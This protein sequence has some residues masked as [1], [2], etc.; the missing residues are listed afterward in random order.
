MSTTV[1]LQLSYAGHCTA[2]AHHA[3]KGAPKGKI[4]FHALWGLIK[5]PQRGYILFDTG[6]TDR[7][8]AATKSWPNKIYSLMT[9]VVIDKAD[10]VRSRLENSGVKTSDVTYIIISH[11]HADHV[12][13][14]KDFPNAQIL[15]SK[16]AYEH[17][18]SIP[19]WRGFAKGVL[20][21][22][23]PEDIKSRVDF[24]EDFGC[25]ISDPKL[26]VGYDLFSDNSVISYDLPGHAAGQIGA[27][28]KTKS[29]SVFLVADAVWD[30]RAITQDLLPHPI[31]K[32]FFDSW[33]DSCDS[34]ERI[35]KFSSSN[36][37]IKIIPTHCS[38][39]TDELI[40]KR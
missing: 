34:I 27:V 31:V 13:G 6:Y 37:E 15:C 25:A 21:D 22:L 11:F 39:T 18:F 28:V 26:G 38:A 9:P 4:K 40:E 23:I 32:L 19:R 10:E 1:E 30:I 35:R 12:A 14:L 36:P 24:V 29:E 8:F 5:H 20:F 17:T 3:V 16:K 7:F 2:S 33:N